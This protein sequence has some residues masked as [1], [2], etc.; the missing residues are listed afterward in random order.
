M[1]FV[2]F[3]KGKLATSSKRVNEEELHSYLSAARG[4]L[5]LASDYLG[6]F[7][8]D[9]RDFYPA[10]R[11]EELYHAEVKQ[12]L[13]AMKS[14]LNKGLVFLD[15]RMGNEINTLNTVKS[16]NQL[17]DMVSDWIR[18]IKADDE[19]VYDVLKILQIEMWGEEKIKRGFPAP[20]NKEIVCGYLVSALNYLNEAKLNV[21]QYM[22]MN[23][24]PDA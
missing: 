9:V 24:L 10:K 15:E 14:G 22:T 5:K 16:P 20:K 3:M 17:K 11:H 8:N 7:L 2:D 4:N 13:V 19:K 18:T 23:S 6:K 21:D 12:K 1:G